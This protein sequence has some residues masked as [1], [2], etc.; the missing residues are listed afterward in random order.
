MNSQMEYVMRSRYLQEDGWS[1]SK[2]LGFLPLAI[3]DGI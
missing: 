1:F 2:A 3:Q